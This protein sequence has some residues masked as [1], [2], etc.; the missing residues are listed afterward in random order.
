MCLS[1]TSSRVHTG[2]DGNLKVEE[3][4]LSDQGWWVSCQDVRIGEKKVSTCFEIWTYS[5]S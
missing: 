3:L 2:R 1:I 4:T 5:L